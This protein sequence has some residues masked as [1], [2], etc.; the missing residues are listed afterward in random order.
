MRRPVAVLT[1]LL[2]AL[3]VFLPVAPASA[4]GGPVRADSG[5]SVTGQPWSA[6]AAPVNCSRQD[7]QVKCVPTSA[8]GV[9]QARCFLDVKLGGDLVTVC[10]S[11][12][13]SADALAGAGQKEAKLAFGCSF[14]DAVCLAMEGMGFAAAIAATAMMYAVIDA[15][16]FSTSGVL[17]DAATGEWSFWAWAVLGALFIASAWA[18][19]SAAVSREK[20]DVLGAIA[21]TFGAV[22]GIPLTLWITGYVVDMFNELNE[23]VLAKKGAVGLFST[24]QQ[25]MWAGGAASYWWMNI[26]C[27]LLLVATVLLMLVFSFRSLALAVLI[28]VGPI[29][30]VLFPV[31][32]IGS[33]WLIRYFSAM[34]ALL[35]TGPLT[36]GLMSLVLSS[37]ANL[38]TIWD[39]QA[40]APLI[41]LLLVAFSPFAAFGLFSVVGGAAVDAIGSRMGD[42]AR[43]SVTT[44]TRQVSRTAGGLSRANATPSGTRPLPSGSSASTSRAS[45]IPSRPSTGG[46]PG[47]GPSSPSGPGGVSPRPSTPAPTS[48]ATRP[49]TQPPTTPTQRRTR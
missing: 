31:R 5:S 38:D 48:G 6:P 46:A 21:R 45:A 49:A 3:M 32:R 35:L 23:Y 18:I 7:N 41:G 24:M 30:W 16:K 13:Q 8:D 44:T 9:Q 15:S 17:W 42:S 40:V 10:T 22:I 36:F 43:R 25:V 47:A 1:A 29:M 27:T 2:A 39:P 11:S 12:K 19:A 34:L 26:M 37:L 4:A 33:Q 14:G 20:S 28:M